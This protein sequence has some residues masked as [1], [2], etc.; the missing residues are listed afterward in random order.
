MP[1]MVMTREKFEAEGE[2]KERGIM[3]T[4]TMRQSVNIYQS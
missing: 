2:E 4:D 1:E 3:M